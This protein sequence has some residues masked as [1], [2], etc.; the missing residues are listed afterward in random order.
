[1]TSC[2]ACPDGYVW[3]R[4]GPTCVVCKICGGFAVVNLD[5][6]QITKEQYENFDDQETK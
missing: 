1:M 3:T 4:E 5:G 6:S 2:P